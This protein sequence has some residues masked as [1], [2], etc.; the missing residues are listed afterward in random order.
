MLPD[1]KHGA[2]SCPTP[3]VTGGCG[4]KMQKAVGSQKAGLHC[5]C[6]QEAPRRV[7]A[8]NPILKGT[9]RKGPGGG[10]GPD[11]SLQVSAPVRVVSGKVGSSV[12]NPP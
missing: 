11:G 10:S 6:E 9:G 1:M 7:V 8:D 5:W 2:I 3:E 12:K 4:A